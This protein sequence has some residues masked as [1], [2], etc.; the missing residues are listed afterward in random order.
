LSQV[1]AT[2]T[3]RRPD[4]TLGAG[5]VALRRF[6]ARPLD[7]LVAFWIFTGGLVMFEPSPY[8]LS[9]LLVLPV[10]LLA[11][12]GF[13]RSTTGLLALFVAFVPFAIIGGMQARYT[14]VDEALIYVLV[15]IFLLLTSFI[16]A[17][18]VA[19]N[20]LPRMR[21]IVRAYTMAAVLCALLGTLA[22][23]RLVPGADQFLLYGRA[24]ATF[25]DPNV[26][27]PFLILPAMF[28][29][30]KA[31]LA[32][33]WRRLLGGAIVLVLFV[34]VFVSFSRAA[35]GHLAASAILV[36]V[37]CFLLEADGR[38]KV[39]MVMMAMA[40]AL[41]LLVAL[42]SLL[43]IPSVAELFEARTAAQTYDEGETGRFGRQAFAFDIALQNP[44]GI[45]PLEFR[46]MRVTEEPHNTYVNVLHVYGWGGGLA[47]YVLVLLTLWRGLAGLVQPSPY[48]R[49]LIPV[50]ATYGV[51]TLEAAIIDTDHWR[52]YFLLVGLIWGLTSALRR[53]PPPGTTH[54]AAVL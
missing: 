29:L 31:L 9:F 22:Y 25:K 13:Y 43:S 26:F 52:H 48:R 49:L 3:L 50:I 45:G 10:A 23:L 18:Y 33:G 28:A 12:M 24:K 42:G 5:V 51:L 35:W 21:L 36:F 53:P 40:G 41:A 30:Q 16:A 2:R 44:W 17:N 8:E 34:G 6:L 47:Y 54:Q 1:L 19:E 15:T 32:T 4:L 7:W 27:G 39:S 38:R 37:L 20:P 46:R 11:G 14:P